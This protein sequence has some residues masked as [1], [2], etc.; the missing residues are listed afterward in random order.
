[1]DETLNTE[2]DNLVKEENM[3]SNEN[4][5][6][7]LQ[8]MES[9]NKN[10]KVFTPIIE[11]EQYIIFN[12]ELKALIENNETIL[13]E[14]KDNKR[15]LDLKYSDLNKIVSNIQISVI[16]LST[17]SGF[18]Q[19]CKDQFLITDN[20]MTLISISISTYISLLLSISKYFKL[21]EIKENIY[22]L[23]IKYSELNNK[24]EYNL[25]IIEP[26][27]CKKLWDL[28][29]QDEKIE[30]WNEV[31][32]SLKKDY[33]QIIELKQELIK[34]FDTNMDSKSINK[35]KIIN[36]ELIYQNNEKLSAIKKK[37]IDQ[38]NN[39]WV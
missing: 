39:L 30:E 1:M 22:N 6:S 12:N 25:D 14:S 29:N 13:N 33:N 2:K 28:Q 15:L 24:L 18:L 11:S 37:E 10:K 36:K 38:K 16:F 27:K 17:I 31:K 35:Y 21:D 8:L 7:T 34:E 9:V 4:I 3:Q 23:R 20:I 19:A 32:N 5:T 26:W